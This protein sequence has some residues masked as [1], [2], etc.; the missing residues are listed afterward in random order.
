MKKAF[1]IENL[2]CANCAA[3]ME[4]RIKKLNG[5]NFA[6]VS[7]ATQRLVLD[8]NDDI[9]DS[10]IEQCKQ[11]CKKIDRNTSIISK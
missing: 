8:A 3:K 1:K 9:F 4:E 6:A 5:V 7:F 11:I 10:V 2:D